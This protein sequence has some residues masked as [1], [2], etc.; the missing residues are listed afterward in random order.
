M[1]GLAFY[2]LADE[3][4]LVTGV[5]G[6]LAEDDFARPTR[7]PA[8]NVKE[9]VAHMWRD[10]DRVREALRQPPP[11]QA[12]TTAVTYWRTYDPIGKGPEIA[13]RAKGIA[14]GFATGAELARSFEENWTEGLEAARA[15]P[16]DRIVLTWGPTMRL[17]EFLAT[18]VL[19]IAVHGLDL[20]HALQRPPWITPGGAA[21]TRA[22]LV[23]LLGDDPP[24]LLGR[25]DV[26]FIEAATG[27]RGLTYAERSVLGPRASAFPL[28][29]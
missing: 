18:R 26:A 16:P 11:G 14:A 15:L 19:E 2:A 12:D 29:G 8:W 20:A 10:M 4:R 23:G 5:A 6:T 17:D 27:R 25:N 28:L 22:I 21:L 24:S 13:D 3:C 1:E 7:L 9:L